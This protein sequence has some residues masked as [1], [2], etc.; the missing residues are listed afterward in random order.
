V[1]VEEELYQQLFGIVGEGKRL[2]QSRA[3][4][5]M[6]VSPSVISAYKSLT[7]NGS[8]AVVEEKIRSFL[9]SEP[10]QA[11]INYVEGPPA[12][13]SEAKEE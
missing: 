6:G 3:A 12:P 13:A 7:Y 9:G 1:E 4:K 5:E 8:I 10:G 2:S 11:H